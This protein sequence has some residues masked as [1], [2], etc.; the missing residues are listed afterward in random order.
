MTQEDKKKLPHTTWTRTKVIRALYQLVVGEVDVL[1][2]LAV[3]PARGAQ[4]ETGQ[5]DQ[6][7]YGMCDIS[8]ERVQILTCRTAY[9]VAL[10]E[11]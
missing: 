11:N 8:V 2:G 7:L 5:R 6:C 3:L 1:P 9:R 4:N 10:R